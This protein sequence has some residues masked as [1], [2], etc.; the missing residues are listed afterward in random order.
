MAQGALPLSKLQ[1]AAERS[2]RQALNECVVGAERS[3][4]QR[5]A[6]LDSHRFSP[7]STEGK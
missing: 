4:S 5:A 6:Q 2:R 3:P 1:A 7:A